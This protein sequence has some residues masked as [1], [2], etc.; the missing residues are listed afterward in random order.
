MVKE[1]ACW[2]W[3]GYEMTGKR[4]D[5]GWNCCFIKWFVNEMTGEWN[6]WLMKRLGIFFDGFVSYLID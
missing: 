3:L 4:N 2:K 6:D 5:R 1:K